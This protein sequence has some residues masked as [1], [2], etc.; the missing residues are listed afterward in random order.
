MQGR[1]SEPEKTVQESSSTRGQTCSV[2]MQFSPRLDS[3]GHDLE[4]Q[5][6]GFLTWD[7]QENPSESNTC[8]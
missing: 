7:G 2:K 8:T 1:A 5:G 4:Y 3:Q 6:Q